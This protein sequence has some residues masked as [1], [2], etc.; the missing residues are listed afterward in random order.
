MTVLVE[1]KY[2]ASRNN[3]LIKVVLIES[4]H[5]AVTIHGDEIAA[6]GGAGPIG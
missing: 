2:K 3:L 5:Y 4:S 1:L 6:V